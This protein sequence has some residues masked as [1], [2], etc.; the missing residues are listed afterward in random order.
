MCR[1]NGNPQEYPMF[2][3]H[4][5]FHHPVFYLQ[6]WRENPEHRQAAGAKPKA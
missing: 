1:E 6:S 2:Q 5:L 3:Y 4:S